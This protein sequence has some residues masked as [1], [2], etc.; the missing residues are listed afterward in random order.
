M[1]DISELISKL[2]GLKD[3][4]ENKEIIKAILKNTCGVEIKPENISLSDGVLK[5][6]I[7]SVEKNAIFLSQEKILKLLQE[8]I[9]DQKITRIL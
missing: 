1:K 7:S 9:K 3:P 5:L 2:T 6:N 8:E 4:K